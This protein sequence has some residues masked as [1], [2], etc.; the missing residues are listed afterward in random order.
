M[1]P[2]GDSIP[3][4]SPPHAHVKGK[5]KRQAR[6]S[7]PPKKKKTAKHKKPPPKLSYEKTYEELD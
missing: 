2:V 1:S 6:P 5:G 7:P 3:S 4:E